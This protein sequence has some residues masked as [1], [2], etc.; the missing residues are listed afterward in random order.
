MQPRLPGTAS[1]STTQGTQHG[2]KRY[3]LGLGAF[4]SERYAD[5]PGKNLP[6]H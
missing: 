5:R 1:S 3:L 6:L 4:M 2:F